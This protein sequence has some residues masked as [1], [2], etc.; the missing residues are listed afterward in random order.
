MWVSDDKLFT[1]I[2]YHIVKSEIVVFGLDNCMENHL[3]KNV[4]KF[5]SHHFRRVTV[6]S[7]HDLIDFF[8]KIFLDRLMGLDL[9]PRAAVLASE[10]YHDIRKIIDIK[11]VFSKQFLNFIAHYIITFPKGCLLIINHFAQNFKGFADF[12]LKI[13]NLQYFSA[14]RTI[15]INKKSTLCYQF[16]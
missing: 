16:L 12:F 10:N 15:N 3:Q 13:C 6:D 9:I 2:S 1:D 5:F 4:A 8:K 7:L 14:F 11:A